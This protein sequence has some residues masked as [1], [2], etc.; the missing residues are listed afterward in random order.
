MEEKV[1]FEKAQ[2]RKEERDKKLITDKKG[3]ERQRIRGG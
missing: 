1:T 2:A 3:R